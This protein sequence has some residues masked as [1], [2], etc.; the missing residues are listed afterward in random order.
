M[1]AITIKIN[2]TTM[3]KIQKMAVDRGMTVSATG[4]QF[5]ERSLGRQDTGQALAVLGQQIAEALRQIAELRA[6][7]AAQEDL[8]K[9]AIQAQQPGLS[10]HEYKANKDIR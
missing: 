4:R 2:S 10:I 1:E 3:R 5:L 9:R 6:V 7:L 8:L